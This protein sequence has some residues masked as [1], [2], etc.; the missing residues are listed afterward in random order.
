MKLTKLERKF[1][2]NSAKRANWP[3]YRH[4][5]RLGW[6]GCFLFLVGLFR[7]R[8]AALPLWAGEILFYTG[9]VLLIGSVLGLAMSTT[10]KL[11]TKLQR[12][13]LDDDIDQSAKP[14]PQ[15]DARYSFL[16]RIESW[17]NSLP[18]WVQIFF[19]PISLV[20]LF[21]IAVTA[22]YLH[23]RLLPIGMYGNLLVSVVLW[24]GFIY[25]IWKVIRWISRAAN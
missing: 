1:A 13:G 15:A 6:V 22:Y 4:H 10:A 2:E 18:W 5:E 20:L 16:M 11:Y 7:G 21:G 23:L 3:V 19:F 25:V 14:P 17:I 12:A 9:F 24:V 8:I